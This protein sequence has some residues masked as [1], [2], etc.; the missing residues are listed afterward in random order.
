MITEPGIAKPVRNAP[1]RGWL[2]IFRPAP[3]A[4]VK[5]TDPAEINAKYSRWQLRVLIFATLGY[6]TFYF[7]RKNYS[8]V[9][10]IIGKD[11]HID[12]PGLG[13]ILTLHGVV[14]GISKFL[15]GFLADRA[16][17]CVFMATALIASALL[18]I[19]F[20]LSSTLGILI[21]IWMLNGWFP[22]HGFSAM[23]PTDGQLVS[24]EAT[25]HQVLHLELLS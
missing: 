8:V 3:P 11:L 2:G 18:N 7:V 6:A 13:L 17:A 20:G 12:K 10:P 4:A 9:Q 21:A 16:N 15:N 1:A 22:R 23:R 24:A 14:Y 5:L 19:W 25:C